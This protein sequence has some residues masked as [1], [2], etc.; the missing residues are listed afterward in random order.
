MNTYD[1]PTS[2]L[3]PVDFKLTGTAAGAMS[4]LKDRYGLA[5]IEQN[6]QTQDIANQT[7]QNALNN[8]LL[9][10]PNLAAQRNID[11]GVM[12]IQQEGINSGRTGD[13][14]KSTQETALSKQELERLIDKR[15]TSEM[16]GDSFIGAAQLIES[17]K[18][19]PA[20][21]LMSNKDVQE[22]YRYLQKQARDAGTPF[23][24][25]DISDPQTQAA[26]GAIA[27][28]FEMGRAERA[29]KTK[30]LE[31]RKTLL[32]VEGVKDTAAE[33]RAAANNAA[34]ERMATEK[35]NNYN[36][37]KDLFASL[38]LDPNVK[39]TPEVIAALEQHLSEVYNRAA[40]NKDVAHDFYLASTDK[41]GAKD[42]TEYAEAV[43]KK[44]VDQQVQKFVQAKAA[45]KAIQPPTEDTILTGGTVSQS[46]KSEEKGM[47][48]GAKRGSEKNPFNPKKE[49]LSPKDIPILGWFIHPETD[50]V[51]QRLQ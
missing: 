18:A 23:P 4:Y 29:A 41:L 12:G 49:G 47:G 24:K 46:V 25:G 5:G 26:I 9:D 45:G 17:G 7:N 1:N 2:L 32:D 38:Y 13:V 16:G 27:N 15:K 34:R 10:N 36:R 40:A 48:A 42:P 21:S 43:K 20:L 33:T 51:V 30:E 37:S 19:N 31:H 3:T 8:K 6:M 44:V 11:S 22:Q 50:K 14:Y 28:R 39:A 35:A